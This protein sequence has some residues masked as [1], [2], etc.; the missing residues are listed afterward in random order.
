VLAA[1]ANASQCKVRAPKRLA[2]PSDWP[3]RYTHR[4]S[5]SGASSCLVDGK[6]LVTCESHSRTPARMAREPRP[7]ARHPTRRYITLDIRFRGDLRRIAATLNN[8][9]KSRPGVPA[10]KHRRAR[11]FGRRTPSI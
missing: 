5:A 6:S 2:L 9:L 3:D 4:D 8:S 7:M 10:S 1:G 11:R